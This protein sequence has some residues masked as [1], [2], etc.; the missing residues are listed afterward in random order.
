MTTRWILLVFL[1]GAFLVSGCAATQQGTA[2]DRI[3]GLVH[4]LIDGEERPVSQASVKLSLTDDDELVG[5]ATTNYA[6]TFFID[7][8]SNRITYREARLRRNQEYLV[9]VEAPEHYLLRQS[10]TF[11]KGAEDW[12]FTLELKTAE[13]GDDP[14][15]QPS[16]DDPT[17]LRPRGSVRKGTR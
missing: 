13:L 11:G 2:G 7:R 5:V 10:F 3:N 12:V 9:E 6:G 16:S 4:S 14:G 1:L 8:L 15:L 17:R